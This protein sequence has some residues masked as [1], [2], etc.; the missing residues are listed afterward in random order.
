MH[1][2]AEKRI[3]QLDHNWGVSILV[4]KDNK[5]LPVITPGERLMRPMTTRQRQLRSQRWIFTQL[6]KLMKLSKRQHGC[7]N[8]NCDPA[9]LKYFRMELYRKNDV[10]I[11]YSE[12]PQVHSLLKIPISESPKFDR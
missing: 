12:Y 7:S 4:P 11:N 10:T 3:A 2:D 6:S 5:S 9:E 8:D 1:A